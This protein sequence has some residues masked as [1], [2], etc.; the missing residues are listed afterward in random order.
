MACT[1][2]YLLKAGILWLYL[3]SNVL[4]TIEAPITLL[5]SSN[6]LALLFLVL[7]FADLM[8][9]FSNQRFLKVREY[10]NHK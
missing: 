6:L 10:Y 3:F 2:A 9:L 4:L 7:G 1:I 8:I 5:M